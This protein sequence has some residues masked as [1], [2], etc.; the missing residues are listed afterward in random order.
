MYE[1]SKQTE[2]ERE[3][4]E[5]HRERE[6]R[7]R[8]QREKERERVRESESEREGA[9]ESVN[10]ISSRSSFF[11]FSSH[12]ILSYLISTY[13]IS[14]HLTQQGHFHSMFLF[15]LLFLF[16][17]YVHFCSPTSSLQTH[18]SQDITPGNQVPLPLRSPSTLVP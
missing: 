16:I 10:D 9:R 3:R 12:L 7:R 2:R 17:Y 18:L 4:E 5:T 11:H 15:L 1:K 13:L 14:S 8:R 6:S